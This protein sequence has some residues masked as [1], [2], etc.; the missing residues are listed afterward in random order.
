MNA[1]QKKQIVEE[2]M[3]A[4]LKGDVETAGRHLADDVRWTMAKSLAGHV[5]TLTSKAQVLARNSGAK[6]MFPEGIKTEIRNVFCDGDSV[7]V[8]FNNQAK[9]SKGKFYDNDYCT[10]F[11]LKGDK[12]KNIREYQDSL[13]VSQILLS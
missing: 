6:S 7:I 2:A 10:V 5:D 9:T 3:R 8:E 13:A 12:I 4:M 1:D 11:Q